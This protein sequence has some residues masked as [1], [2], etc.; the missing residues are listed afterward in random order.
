MKKTNY[1]KKAILFYV[2]VIAVGI[3]SAATITVNPG[4]NLKSILTGANNGDLIRINPGLYI[5]DKMTTFSDMTVVGI[6]F[7]DS[8][9]DLSKIDD[10]EIHFTDATEADNWL[11]NGK[12]TVSGIKFTGGDHQIQLNNEGIVSYC[13][14]EGG[15]DQCSFSDDGYGDV[16]N[17]Q[18]INAGDDGVDIDCLTRISGA[19]I[20]VHDNYFEGTLEDGIEFR[21]YARGSNPDLLVYQFYN[22]TFVNCG[23]KLNGSG[24]P[25][26]GD[27]IQM[28]DHSATE[29]SREILI[30]NNVIDG[31]GTTWNGISC[32]AKNADGSKAQS[33][34]LRGAAGM[35]EDLWIY[36]N[37]ILNTKYGGINGGDNTHVFNNI[38]KNVPSG[39]VRATVTNNL[40]HEVSTNTTNVTDFGSNHYNTDPQI[41]ISSYELNP[42]SYSIDKGISTYTSGGRTITPDFTGVAP[43][44]GGIESPGGPLEEFDL[45]THTAGAGTGT[46]SPSSGTYTDGEMITLTATA[47]AG[48]EFDFWSGDANGTNPTINI[49]M[50][51]DKDITANFKVYVPVYYTLTIN[52]D[53]NGSGSVTPASGQSYLSG[54]E[55]DLIATADAGSVFA[56]WS[57]NISETATTTTISID[58]NMTVTATFIDENS[59]AEVTLDPTDDAWVKSTAPNATTGANTTLKVNSA[60]K[61]A[62][63]KFDLSSISTV[64]TAYLDITSR[65]AATI[66]LYKVFND[67][68][69]EESVT[70]STKP[71]VSSELLGTYVFASAETQRVTVTNFVSQQA[72]EDDAVSFALINTAS[73]NIA[74]DS[75]EGPNGPKLIIEHNVAPPVTYNLTTEAI[76]YGTVSTSPANGPYTEGTVV[77]LTAIPDDG[78]YFTGW[79]GDASGTDNPVEITMNSNKSVTATF[80]LLPL[81]GYTSEVIGGGSLNI[82]NRTYVAGT[83]IEITATPDEG[84]AFSGW[85]GDASGSENPFSLEMDEDKHVIATF[86]ESTGITET[87]GPTDDSWVNSSSV[88]ANYGLRSTLKLR[89]AG[90]HGLIKFDLS[91]IGTV[92]SATLDITADAAGTVEL[93]KV[94]NDAWDEGSVTW[95][96]KPDTTEYIGSYTFTGAGTESLVVTQYIETEALNDDAASFALIETNNTLIFVDSKEGAN[97]PVLTVT[98][99][100]V[101]KSAQSIDELISNISVYPNPTTGLV[102]LKLSDSFNTGELSVINALG[103]IVESYTIDNSEHQLNIGDY[104]TGLYLIS[105]VS[106]DGSR[107]LGTVLM[108]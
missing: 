107:Y 84:W 12:L 51:S 95:N 78:Y 76:P 34:N 101:P 106:Q 30:Y 9:N 91:T 73:S 77:T 65:A 79:S 82:E 37:T 6:P 15:I 21:L 13:I 83:I 50:D 2:A 75:K 1:L 68:W 56:G 72:I 23:T 94:S 98:H 20:N 61:Q 89:D 87:F 64:S 92:S 62:F 25:I 31:A 44:L 57:G 32:N 49:I 10:V 40:T 55:V 19:Y 90:K 53:G 43:D 47:D 38:I 54:T 97:G 102:N 36:N 52:T 67:A 88:N 29:D 70:W 18:F 33:T 99:D 108:Y 27:G 48:Y 86:V 42:G 41:N 105:V 104:P 69:S 11:T 5:I 4:D 58:D 3:V 63:I 26:G 17:C 8:N 103:T 93:W 85:S 59:V 60:N 24:N 39:F 100:G 22:N 35:Q 80:E 28:I 81:Y 7:D 16:S 74:L 45:V 96:T 66:E 46:V 14:F 71:D